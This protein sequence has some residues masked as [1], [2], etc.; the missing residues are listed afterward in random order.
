MRER[1][2][3]VDDNQFAADALARILTI[4]GYDAIAVYGGQ[5]AVEQVEKLQPELALIDIGM[6]DVDGF[7]VAR[8]IRRQGNSP[9]VILVALT[10]WAR[11][12][13]R[14][15]A[16]ECGYDRHMAKPICL[17]SLRNVLAMLG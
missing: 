17:E 6:P 5:Q 11:E 12:E 16:F 15:R 7:E 4:A 8:R 1:I 3:V 10:A 13:D 2:L 14:R 9:A